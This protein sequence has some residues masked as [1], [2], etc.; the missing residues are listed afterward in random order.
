MEANS[1]YVIHIQTFFI[2][3][4]QVLMEKIV[5][6]MLSYGNIHVSMI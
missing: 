2:S 5:G 3:I 1:S 4:R 6:S